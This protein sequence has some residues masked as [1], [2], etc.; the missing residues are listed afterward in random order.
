MPRVTNAPATKARRKRILKRAK[1]FFGNKSRL[2]RY[3][4]N[5]V[6]RAEVYAYRDRRSRKSEFRAL[7]IARINAGVRPFGLSYSRFMEGLKA[8]NIELDRKTISEMAINDE[9]AFNA[10]VETAKKALA[11]K[12][13]K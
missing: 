2:Y 9:A 4:K 10:L 3:A 13:K 1:G 5:A 12:A 11:D 8:A 6:A 7:W